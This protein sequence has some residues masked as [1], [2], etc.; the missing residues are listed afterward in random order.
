MRAR[1]AC[2][3]AARAA[4]AF[5]AL[6][7]EVVD[8]YACARHTYTVS[9]LQTQHEQHVSMRARRKAAWREQARPSGRV[10]TALTFQSVPY[11]V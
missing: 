10:G 11:F 4:T 7:A 5:A 2:P 3:C 8:Y 6:R 9:T 1:H